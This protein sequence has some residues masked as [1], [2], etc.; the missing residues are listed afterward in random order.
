MKTCLKRLFL[1]ILLC[2]IFTFSA[3]TLPE[4]TY[5]KREVAPCNIQL[6]HY[7]EMGAQE[8]RYYLLFF[9]DP[10]D[11]FEEEKCTVLEEL[12][13]EQLENFE[14]DMLD[15]G[16]CSSG[17]AVT[18]APYGN[19]LRIVYEDGSFLVITWS[20]FNPSYSGGGFLGEYDADGRSMGGEIYV[21]ATAYMYIAANYFEMKI[22]Y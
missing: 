17:Q 2:V 4:Y 1:A 22:P 6:I 19:G 12:P 5:R 3:C 18:K 11:N 7:D 9:S 13:V 14:Q 15:V 8:Q 16:Y 10:F 20:K 21:D